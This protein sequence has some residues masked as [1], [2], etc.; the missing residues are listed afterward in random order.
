MKTTFSNFFIIAGTILATSF[1]P[2]SE[3]EVHSLV[4]KQSGEPISGY[5]NMGSNKSPFGDI[6]S[7]NSKN[8]LYNI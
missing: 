7:I 3:A 8:I 1:L 6:I 4:V 5:F 2:T